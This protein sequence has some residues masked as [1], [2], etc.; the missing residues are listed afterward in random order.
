MQM[1]DKVYRALR[2]R[3]QEQYDT[4][5]TQLSKQYALSNTLYKVGDIIKD[6]IR[7]IEILRLRYSVPQ[8]P[9][10]LP[11]CHYKGFEL[12]RK[13]VRRKDKSQSTILSQWIIEEE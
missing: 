1:E 6:N 7:S 5:L 10:K 12:T 8:N 4:S 9:D 3:V 13:G 2:A 11:E